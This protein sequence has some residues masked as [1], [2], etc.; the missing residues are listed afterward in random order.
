MVYTT[1]AFTFAKAKD[2]GKVLKQ[3]TNWQRFTTVTLIA[4]AIIFLAHL[5][6]QV[7]M[8][9]TWVIVTGIATYLGRKFFDLTGDTYGAI[10]ETAEVFVLVLACLL[11]Y[12]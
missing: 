11:A 1:F 9:G 10:N 4:L 2:L 6:V 8:A 12:N 3:E 5:A 7:T